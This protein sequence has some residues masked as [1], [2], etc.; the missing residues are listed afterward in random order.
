MRHKISLPVSPEM[1][2]KVGSYSDSQEIVGGTVKRNVGVKVLD[3]T[4][5]WTYSAPSGNVFA[6]G[7]AYGQVQNAALFCTHYVGSGASNPRNGEMRL[8]NAW[9]CLIRD[10]RFN[11]D[12]TAFKAY[13][14]AQ[15]AAGTP[16]I[17]V[18]PLAAETTETV[19]GR[20][21]HLMRG[22]N[23]IYAES[24]LASPSFTFAAKYNKHE[25][26]RTVQHPWTPNTLEDGV[27]TIYQS[28]QPERDG[29]R[30]TFD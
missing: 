17:V 1:L 14:A 4:E 9:F 6:I 23:T 10:D 16:V 8:G 11:A 7:T 24:P 22:Q 18:Y 3:G 20:N 21:L 27:L 15:Y 28:W 13:L 26:F 25:G 2:L 19:T 5:N 29:R 30:L 12:V